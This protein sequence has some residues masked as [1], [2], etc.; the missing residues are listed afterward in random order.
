MDESL[1]ITDIHTHVL[2]D[3]DDGPA[4]LEQSHEL[5]QAHMEAG[6]QRIFCTSHYLS[7][8]FEVTRTMLNRAYADV[9]V[10]V[11]RN[12]QGFA[13]A[14]GAEVRIT[15][16]LSDDLLA[17]TIPTLGLTRYV[18]IEFP[19]NQISPE[20]LALVHD[21]MLRDLK[22]IM[23]HPERNIAIQKNPK[24][25]SELIDLGLLLQLTAR[26]FANVDYDMHV[27]D[28]LAWDILESGHATVI[29]SDA[30]N[31]MT[32][33]PGLMNGYAA[34]EERFGSE[35]VRRLMSN[36]NAIWNDEP[37]AKVPARR[38]SRQLQKSLFA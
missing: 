20:H 10:S 9:S 12:R 31:V 30:H 6:T 18:L 25:V 34:I 14:K 5:L 27:G 8:H 13:I 1:I 3:I 24:L 11:S 29:A 22:P 33:P 15:P 28:R 7:P 37:V 23:A 21:L 17:G 38:A 19:N 35:V 32:R 36:A 26:C 4:Y 16:D 2:P